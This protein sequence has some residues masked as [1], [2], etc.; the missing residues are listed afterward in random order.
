MT[1]PLRL[2]AD[3]LPEVAAWAMAGLRAAGYRVD[4]PD[5]E[6]VQARTWSL[7]FPLQT[8]RGRVWV[9]ANARD[10]RC[11]AALL[12]LI[13]D[14]DPTA[15]LPLLVTDIDLGR[16]V[17]PDGGR[18]LRGEA[19]ATS[20]QWCALLSDYADLQKLVA[21]ADLDA[22]PLP[23]QRPA[24][25]PHRWDLAVERCDTEPDL[26]ALVAPRERDELRAVR[27]LVQRYASELA[28]DPLPDS[29]DHNDL[30]PGNVFVTP[31][32][33]RIFDWG[34]ATRS[35]PF[36]SLGQVLRTASGI[37]DEPSGLDLAPLR[38]AYLRRWG[39]P[40]PWLLRSA[41]IAETLSWVTHV[42]S[43]VRLPLFPELAQWYVRLL[44]S[45]RTALADQAAR[46]D[47]T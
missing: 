36:T 24:H 45:A 29:V 26:A 17:T 37:W 44:R 20:Q 28:A 8:D 13:A 30:H 18:T 27:G 25:L 16:F 33:L 21:T 40:E 7:V 11:E 46:D 2:S 32:G 34:D 23:D 6:Q 39:E 19:A 41:E 9:K 5:P 47:G 3:D 42:G 10:F 12:R 22:L 31:A 38:Q 35:H 15:V 4:P 1:A 43:W 14:L